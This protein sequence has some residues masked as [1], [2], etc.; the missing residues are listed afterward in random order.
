MTGPAG[1]EKPAKVVL[2]PVSGNYGKPGN[3]NSW[4]P[5]DLPRTQLGNITGLLKVMQDS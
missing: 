1:W 4:S 2:L 3:L 5:A